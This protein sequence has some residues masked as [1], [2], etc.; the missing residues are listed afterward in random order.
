MS[1]RVMPLAGVRNFRDFGGYAGAAGV[2]RRGRLFRSAHFAEASA[3]DAAALDD[4]GVTVIVDLRRPH[5]RRTHPNRWPPQSHA[6][7][8]LHDNTD[9]DDHVEAPH[10]ALLRQPDLTADSVAGFMVQ[11]Y[12]TV[13]FEARH[14][15][16]FAGYFQALSD[17][18]ASGASVVHCAAGKDRTGIA[19]A[20]V[21]SAL[22]VPRDTVMEDYLL[23][24]RAVDLDAR[25][26]QIRVMIEKE[27]GRALD[28]ATVRP[29]LGVD[30]RYLEAAFT[31][32]GN[33]DRYLET[34]LGVD[35][36]MRAKLR[37]RL[38][39]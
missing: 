33:V 14:Q 19:C 13:P 35:E 28:L 31:A 11:L 4:L 30:A 5:E 9:P 8:I 25:A 21:L 29:M 24:N 7:Q 32:I 10:I 22:G 6:A 2:V 36:T 3:E 38:L 27:L 12:Q 23:T 18:R 26:P 1:D 17:D 16:L 15:R 39:E 20:L 34:A 37:A